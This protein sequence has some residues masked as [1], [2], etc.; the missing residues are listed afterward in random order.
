MGVATKVLMIFP[1]FMPHA[2]WSYE[3][4]LDLL[5]AKY[6]TTPLGMITVA[7]LLPGD[8]D[9]RLV[10]RNTREV[11]EADLAWA[12]MVM[13][14][15]MLPQQHDALGIIDMCRA[16]HLPVVVGGPDA[17]SSPQIYA[18]ADFRVLGEAESVIDDF[19]AA[20]RAGEREGEF[21][22]P[23]FQADV[24][25]S[26][27][28][29]FDLL[30]FKDYL[31]IGVQFSRGCPFTCEF[32][33]IIELYGRS[34]RAKTIP[35][36]LAELDALYAL[37]YRGP[38]D[39]VDDNLIGN[40]KA[41]KAFLPHLIEW[42][43]AHDYPYSLTTE[44]SLNIA[45]DTALMT[46]M[47]EANFFGFFVGIESPDPE[48]LVHMSKKQNIKREIHESVRKIYDHGMVVF[49]GF[50]IGFDTEKA[51]VAEVMMECIEDAA[52]PMAMVGLLYALPLTQ[53][54]RRLAREGRLHPAA[55]LDDTR[56]WDDISIVGLNFDT[57]RPRTDILRDFA[58]VLKR[59]YEPQA[60][61]DRVRRAFLP[62]RVKQHS[63]RVQYREAWRE[64]RR[65]FNIM[66]EITLR[67]PDMRKH[68]WKL[69]FL[70]LVRNSNAM[71]AFLGMVVFYLYLAPL[72]RLWVAGVE[73]EIA[74]LEAAERGRSPVDLMAAAE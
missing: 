41:V 22:A 31:Y 39:F 37:G 70:L 57:L 36:M 3:G 8:W 45:D 46:M 23:K 34:P 42:Q 60:Y 48:T 14:G 33:D 63:L 20:W 55:E 11:T 10:N 71:R 21:I 56:K 29:R 69:F 50:I 2:F 5:G 32:C 68:V 7:A 51:R 65:L 43:K 73:A 72:A 15:G 27:I 64:K 35:Q 47:R 4:A 24:T 19:I 59:L 61:F 25:K 1:Q 40:K 67:R 58:D 28:P 49:P 44:A 66:R 54:T 6:P 18:K 52:L 74:R 9:V 13:T 26:P 16:R 12:D 30:T 38:L 53:L 17:T 62:M